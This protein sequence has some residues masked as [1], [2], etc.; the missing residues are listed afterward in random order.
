MFALIRADLL[1][2]VGTDVTF[3]TGWEGVARGEGLA[4]VL[5]FLD[6][7]DAD[8]VRPVRSRTPLCSAIGLTGP[9]TYSGVSGSIAMGSGA[10]WGMDC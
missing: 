5:R 9:G 8:I 2:I 4:T 10:R 3:R 6:G 1:G 7:C